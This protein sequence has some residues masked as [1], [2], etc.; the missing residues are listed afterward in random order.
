MSAKS[1]LVTLCLAVLVLAVGAAAVETG[2]D[3][4][5]VTQAA[6]IAGDADAAPAESALP[7]ADFLAALSSRCVCRCVC[8][9]SGASQYQC[10]PQP[11]GGSCGSLNGQRCKFQPASTCDVPD[12]FQNCVPEDVAPVSCP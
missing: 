7:T 3:P 5:T 6:E 8:P 4:P 2:E 12:I 1:L 11:S 10:V 9:S